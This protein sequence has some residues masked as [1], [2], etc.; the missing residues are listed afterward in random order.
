MSLSRWQ[1][2]I[3]QSYKRCFPTSFS[4][5]LL[6]H[7]NITRIAQLRCNS[8]Q[9]QSKNQ[10]PVGPPQNLDRL[11]KFI[12]KSR[13][14]TKLN[15]KPKFRAYFDKLAHTSPVSTITSFLILHEITAIV[16]LFGLWW[17]LYKLNLDEQYNLPVYFK[18]LLNQCGDSIEK[19]VDNYDQGFD[20]NRLI[21][22][23]AVSYAIVKVL[24]PIRVL[25][26]LWAA[27]FFLKW[28]LAPFRK[29]GQL[30]KRQKPANPTDLNDK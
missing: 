29:L 18:E 10:E 5:G 26:S 4:A 22:S 19:L 8:T 6:V 15:E 20:R 13:F 12:A 30:F 2:G 3:Q 1:L 24:Y 21:L 25:V 11:H 16:P 14:L 27:P 9:N 17:A 28:V 23:G 7:P